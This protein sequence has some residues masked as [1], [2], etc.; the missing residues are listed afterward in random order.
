MESLQNGQER[1][2]PKRVTTSHG[3]IYNYLPDGRTQR[4]K[5]A[6]QKMSEPQD[7]LVYIPPWEKIKEKAKEAYPKVFG[8]I[9]DAVDYAQ[10]LLKFAQTESYTMRVV[11]ETGKELKSNAETAE[12]KRVL[13]CFV[14]KK[15][16]Q[17]SFYLPVS[18]EPKVGYQT[19]DT[20]KYK[21]E[22][23]ET[24]RQR[25]VGNEVTEIEYE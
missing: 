20:R 4:F 15:N 9:E 3:S 12:A 10:L 2:K 22:H 7:T 14:D 6:E 25:H 18:I 8:S 11:D 23:G 24:L 13:I 17:D 1:M 5:T 16:I 21:D 19:Y